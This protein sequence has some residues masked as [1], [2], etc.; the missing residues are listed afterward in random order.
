M[1]LRTTCVSSSSTSCTRTGVAR[2]PTS[3]SSSGASARR[4]RPGAS[5]SSEPPPRSPAAVLSTSRRSRSRP[6]RAACSE[7][8]WSRPRCHQRDTRRATPPARFAD[9]PWSGAARPPDQQRRRGTTTRLLAG[10]AGLVGRG[11]VRPQEEPGKAVSFAWVR[12]RSVARGCGEDARG[13]AGVERLLRRGDRPRALRRLRVK[14]PGPRTRPSPSGSTSSSAGATPS[15]RGSKRRTE[16]YLTLQ[17][18]RLRPSRPRPRPPP[19]RVL[20]FVRAGYYTVGRRKDLSG[21]FTYEPREVGGTSPPTT[22]AT[23]ASSTS[24]PSSPWPDKPGR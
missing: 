17:G 5:R 21:T 8:Q 18:Q 12:D 16:R 19:P 14:V 22:T 23:A 4:R 6:S 15:M 11:H 3:R 24:A 1:A 20:S 9:R 10:P 2:A 7:Q 13:L